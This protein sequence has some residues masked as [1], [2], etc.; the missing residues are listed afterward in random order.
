VIGPGV[1]RLLLAAAAV[2]LALACLLVIWPFVAPILWAVI[3]AYVSWPLYRWLRTLLRGVNSAAALLMTVIIGCLVVLPVL[4]ILVLVQTELVG[5]YKEL[6]GYLAQGPPQL[7]GFVRRIPWVGG[8]AQDAL[9]HFLANPAV[10]AREA[11]T[12]VLSWA[13]RLGS[14]VGSVGRNLLKLS[15]TLLTLFFF[16]RD[17]DTI[18]AQGRRVLRRFFTN[19][20]D[21]YLVT[22]GRMTRAVVYGLLITAC[23]QG[24]IAG[25]GYRVVGLATPVLLGVLTGILSVVP[26]VGTAIV[27]VPV[28]IWLMVAGHLIKG[29]I[30]LAWGVALVH[31]PESVLRPLLISNATRLPFL[32]VLF[33]ALGGLSTFGLIGLFA[34]PVLLAIAMAVWRE[35]AAR[36]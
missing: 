3:L 14:I 2:A 6:S 35:W 5:A 8:R 20:L 18:V 36:V 12:W 21:G 19:R 9:Q 4:Y 25:I 15:L 11:G 1:R 33:G 24:L 22:A 17:G 28:A 31:P 34:G 10:L 32:L 29:I 26:L 30:L 7:P 13:S 27:W 16:F 23:A